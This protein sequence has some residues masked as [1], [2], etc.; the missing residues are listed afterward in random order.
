M[1]LES[2]WY[3][4]SPVVYLL[5]GSIATLYDAGPMLLKLSG[6]LLVMTALTMLGLRMVWR[7]RAQDLFDEDGLRK[8]RADDLFHHLDQ[9][10]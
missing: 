1:T 4:A 7:R 10:L 2:L 5:S 8:L 6:L 9:R 3:E